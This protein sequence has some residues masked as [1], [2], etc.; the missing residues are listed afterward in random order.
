MP[1]ISACPDIV[2]VGANEIILIELT[3]PYNLPDCL[4]NAKSRKESKET[5]QHAL[6]NL[7]AK[8]MISQPLTIEIGELGHWLPNTRSSLRQ[9]V[10]SLSKS[11]TTHLLD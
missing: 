5:Y 6:N 9:Q 7:A 11:A 8:G 3:V 2:I 4:H 10:S 1:D